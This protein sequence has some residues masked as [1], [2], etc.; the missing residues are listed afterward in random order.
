MP[1]QKAR[2]LA[3]SKSVKLRFGRQADIRQ[4]P[5]TPGLPDSL[6]NLSAVAAQGRKASHLWLAGDEDARIERLSLIGRRTYGAPASFDLAQILTG[7]PWSSAARVTA[8]LPA[9]S[10][11]IAKRPEADIEGLAVEDGYL[12]LVGSHSLARGKVDVARN[13]AGAATALLGVKADPLR[14]LLARI[15]VTEEAEPEVPPR[16]V[17]RTAGAG[18]AGEA[19]ERQALCLRQLNQAAGNVLTA[20]LL[21]DPLIAPFLAI[22]AKDNGFDVEGIAVEPGSGGDHRVLLGLR[23]P[24]LRGQAIALALRLR[25]GAD[26]LE[27]VPVAERSYARCFLDLDGLGIRDLARDGRDILVLAG[28]TMDLDGPVGVWRWRNA[29]ATI[30]ADRP[31]PADE[32]KHVLALPHGRGCDHAEGM[33]V[34]KRAGG[35]RSLLVVFDSPGPKR[36]DCDGTI[37]AELFD[38]PPR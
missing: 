8:P 32:L 14:Y 2:E 22:P 29:F 1:R 28:P 37:R 4:L 34:V 18:T 36:I 31:V 30:T 3:K 21:A 38:L 25:P 23:G 15:P 10:T 19:G 35:R 20:A 33:T 12:W 9:G 24:V 5:G 16:L 13:P 11:K 17:A 27:L 6:V 26:W 7:L